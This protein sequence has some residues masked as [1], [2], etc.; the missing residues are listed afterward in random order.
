MCSLN[1]GVNYLG[2]SVMEVLLYTFRCRLNILLLTSITTI[3]GGKYGKY[4]FM[5]N[6]YVIRIT[7]RIFMFFL[8][9]MWHSKKLFSN[10]S[11][12]FLGGIG[13]IE[14]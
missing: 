10:L 6:L 11:K 7:L 8:F 14:M 13:T 2:M 4:F 12:I 1:R 5:K 9:F 3:N